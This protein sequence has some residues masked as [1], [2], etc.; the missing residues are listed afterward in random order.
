MDPAPTVAIVGRPNVGKSTLFNRLIGKRHAIIA[1]EA[2]TTRDRLF[3]RWDCNGYETLLVDTGGL[4]YGK[5][6]DIESDIQSQAAIAIEE[7]DVILFVI[8]AAQELTVDDFTAANILRKTNKPVIIVANKCD[9]L[10]IETLSFNIYELGFGD[11]IQVSAIHK[12]GIEPL[13]SQIEKTLKKLKF[14]KSP[15]KAKKES[16]IPICILGKPNAGKSSLVNA[17]LG[18]D[19]VIVSEIAG[20]TRDITD[21]DITFGDQKYTLIDTAGI[22]RPGKTKRGIEKFSALRCLTG[23]ERSEVVV[24][25]IDG[26]LGLT[27]QD[28]H[29]AELVLEQKKGLIITVNKIDLME[30]GEELRDRMIGQLR[31]R[32]SFIPW[33]PIVFISAKNKKNTR[34]I[35]KLTQAIVEERKKRIKTAE[36]NVF[37][38]KATHK[39]LPASAKNKKPKFFY[40]SQVEINPPKF[41]LFFRNPE[42]LHFSYPRYIE[43]SLRKEFGFNGTS[44]EIRF[45][46]KVTE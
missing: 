21:T 45:K 13:E 25:L 8:D 30:K 32:L 22:K 9:N 24:L 40:G 28:A 4:E 20:T 35:L 12:T 34:E 31:R 36:L 14:K 10:A 43:N 26:D 39:H 41:V 38:Q 37:L 42:N 2:G 1:K 15:K 44:I 29:I 27:S 23:I 16:S 18:E 5:K 6:E 19:K 7:A 46:S 3:Q 17:L 33:A 11:P